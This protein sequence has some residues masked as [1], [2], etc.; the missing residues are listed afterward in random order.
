MQI[1]IRQPNRNADPVVIGRLRLAA[2]G[3]VQMLG[4]SP[5]L[6]AFLRRYEAVGHDGRRCS[7]QDGL[8]FLEALPHNLRGTRLWAEQVESRRRD[9]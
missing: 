5:G 4:C 2:D 8:A 9:F 1:E 3:T 7:V 6:S